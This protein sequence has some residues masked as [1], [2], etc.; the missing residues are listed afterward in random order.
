MDEGMAPAPSLSP[1]KRKPVAKLAGANAKKPT[2]SSSRPKPTAAAAAAGGGAAAPKKAAKL[3]P[4]SGPEEVRYKFSAE[5]AEARVTEVIPENVWNDFAQSQWK[6]RLAAMDAL[7]QHF[8]GMDPISTEPEL[9]FRAL[10]KKPGWKEM[11][12]Q[13]MGK[14]FGVMQLL[15]TKCSNFSKSCVAIGN[16]GKPT[17]LG[18]FILESL[19]LV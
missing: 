13:V 1:P 6:V 3:P 9:V 12:F 11:N 7:Y 10:S 14:L 18:R 19:I 17:N 4:P 8:D 15:A 2:L 16:Q 5:D